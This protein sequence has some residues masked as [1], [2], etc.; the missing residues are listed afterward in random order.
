MNYMYIYCHV[1][2]NI[3][4]VHKNKSILKVM[5]IYLIRELNIRS[6]DESEFKF[7]VIF[8]QIIQAFLEKEIERIDVR[9]GKLD[10]ILKRIEIRPEIILKQM[11]IKPRQEYL[12]G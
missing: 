5:R 1:E 12:D 7:G 8:R 3:V 9:G 4:F 2:L 11:E 10:N 6:I